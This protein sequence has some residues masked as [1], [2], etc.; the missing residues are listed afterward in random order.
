MV[1]FLQIILQKK[2]NKY[3]FWDLLMSKNHGFTLIELL[4]VITILA[5]L[6]GAALPFVQ[7]Y[8]QESRISKAKA[9]LDEIS[10]ALMVYE[11]R[12]GTYNSTSIDQIVGRYLNNS[13]IDPWGAQYHVATESG[14]VFSSGPDRIPNNYDDISAGYQPPLAL[15][16][17]KWVDAN[18]TGA[19]DTQ[20]RPDYLMLQFSR[21]I[22]SDSQALK[23]PGSAYIYFYCTSSDTVQ[24]MFDWS[25]FKLDNSGSMITLPLADGVVSAFTAGSDTFCV[26]NGDGLRDLASTTVNPGGNKCISS[27]SVVIMSSR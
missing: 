14:I 16:N 26:S 7:N 10:R 13:P 25:N 8:V 4:V 23:V 2:I 19:V 24:N 12:E 3:L 20:N 1:C 27:Q 22:S 9:D 15:V 6:V 11:T 17:V 18:N 5:I 21:K